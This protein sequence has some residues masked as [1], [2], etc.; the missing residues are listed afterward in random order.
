GSTSSSATP[1]LRTLHLRL[2]SFTEKIAYTLFL[3]TGKSFSSLAFQYRLGIST[4]AE[5]VHMT[6]SAIERQMMFPKPTEEMWKS[7]ASKF[8]NKLNFSDCIGAIDGKHVTIVSPA[9]SGSLYFNYK[10]TFSIVLL[11]LADAEYRF[12]FLQVGDFGRSSDGGV[13]S[14]SVLGRAMEAQKLSVPADCPL[15]GSGAQGPM[16]YTMVGDAAFPLKI[17][18]MRPFPGKQIPQ[19]RCIFNYR[20]SRARM[21]IE[22]AFGILS[23]RWRVL[24]TKMNM[25]PSN[26]DSVVTATCILH[27]YLLNPSENQK[28]LDEAEERGEVLPHVRHMGGNRGCREAYDV[29]ERLCTFFNSPEGRVSW[30]EQMM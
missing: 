16:P 18:L 13:Y 24:H 30:Q 3:G 19:W 12:T 11:A 29:R 8:W 14:G 23:S 21:V 15:P 17:N 25:M 9:H 26:A 5:S 28:W 1:S 7:I 4:V 20:L 2:H 22:C 10:G 6:C 27:S